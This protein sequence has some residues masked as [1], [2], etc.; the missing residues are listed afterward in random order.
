MKK[1]ILML[2]LLM[3]LPAIP[4]FSQKKTFKAACLN[5]DGL[6]P[7]VKASVTTVKLNP[8][9]PQERGTERMSELI[10]QK[11]WDFFGISEN[12]NYNDQLMSHLTGYYNTGTYRGK[13]TD[14]STGNA[15]SA[16][17]GNWSFDTDGLN[18][19]WKTQFKASNESWTLW[20]KRNGITDAGSDQLIKKGFRYYC[21]K[22]DN[23]LEIDVYIHHMDAET[24][25]ADIAARESQLN[26]LVD[27]IL[28]SDNHRPI[29]IMGDTNCRYT[30]DRLQEILF[31]RINEDLRFDI[32]DPWVDFMWDG[33]F[34]QYGTESMMVGTYGHQKGE[35]V[36]KIFYINNNDANGIVLTAN[37]YL[38]DTDFSYPDG[39]EISDH[40]PIVINF[41]IENTNTGLTGGEYYM[42]NVETGKYLCPGGWWGTHAMV[43][44]HGSHLEFVPTGE[45]QTFN[46]TTPQGK[47]G[48]N[49]YLDN[50]EYCAFKFTPTDDGYYTVTGDGKTLIVTGD[51]VVDLAEGEVVA[52]KWELISSSEMTKR[53]YQ[54]SDTN[55]MDAT[56]FIKGA[57]FDRNDADVNASWTWT[58]NSKGNQLKYNKGGINIGDITGNNYI[59][60]FKNDKFT[61]IL[62][63]KNS[64]GKLTHQSIA[65]LPN[66]KYHLSW[67]S[68]AKN[69][70]ANFKVTVNGVSTQV[71]SISDGKTEPTE[72]ESAA[73]AFNEGRYYQGIDLTITDHALN[74]V[75]EKPNT[76]S[77]TWMAFDNFELTYYG[78]T[79]ENRASYDRVLAAME[80][81]A[82]KAEAMHYYNYD[83]SVVEE[84]YENHLLSSDGSEEVHMTYIALANAAKSQNAIPADMRYVV[85][86]NSFEMG[87]FTE[88]NISGASNAQVVESDKGDGAYVA[89]AEGGR[90]SQELQV[91]MPAGLY[92]VT[93]NVSN[94]VR[95][96]AGDRKSD[97]AECE[98]GEM[99][100]ISFNFPISAGTETIGAE[101]AGAFTVDNFRIDRI[102][103]A[104]KANAIELIKSALADIPVRVATLPEPHNAPID[105]SNYQ[106]M[107]DEYAVSG[108]GMTEFIEMYGLLRERVYAQEGEIVDMTAA[109][110]NNSFEMGNMNGWDTTLS[111]DTGVKPNTDNTYHCN[112]TDGNYLFN[113]WATGHALTQV[114]Y[115]LPAGHYK[116]QALASSG[117]GSPR[118]VFLMGNEMHS[119]AI[120]IPDDKANLTEVEYEFDVADV[121][122]VAIGIIGG[123]ENGKYVAGGGNWYKADNFR[124]TRIG[125]ADMTPFYEYLQGVI[126][127]ATEKANT[128]PEAYASQWDLSDYQAIID[129]QTLEGDG[130]T[131]AAEIYAALRE[132]VYSQTEIG[133]DLT[134]NIVNNSFETGD[135]T[136]W[137]CITT[138][139]TGVRDNS[140]GTYHCDNADGKYVFNTWDSGFASA[141]TQTLTGV[142][143]GTYRLQALVAS[144]A[145]NQYFLA[146]NDNISEIITTVVKEQMEESEIIFTLEEAGDVVIGV[147]PAVNGEFVADGRGAWYKADN[148]RL[149]R[150]AAPIVEQ[151]VIWTMEGKTY[152]TLI[153]PFDVDEIPEG[154]EVYSAYECTTDTDK[155]YHVLVLD[156]VF[157]I[158]ANR[159]YVVKRPKAAAESKYRI[160]AAFEEDNSI[161]FTGEPCNEADSYTHGVLTGVLV[162]TPA[163]AG[164]YVMRHGEQIST[165]VKHAGAEEFIIPAYH[166]YI[167]ASNATNPVIFMDQDNVATAVRDLAADGDAIVDVYDMNGVV[168]ARGV[169]KA[170]ALD[171]LENGIYLFSDGTRV[172]RTK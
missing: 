105:L 153:L 131:E 121:T 75:I 32:H 155:D 112:N 15:F 36:D 43:G 168:V 26:Q 56:F 81:A 113:T 92:R 77:A 144:D 27:A 69:G 34:P 111:T 61:A 125:T 9:G 33:V 68:F 37:S 35:V 128:L 17:G 120:S 150:A 130:R 98:E 96:I 47:F 119:E 172:L 103:N 109:I 134:L 63:N 139:D 136:G 51:N 122:D 40:Y 94:G 167:D 38:H 86:N 19:L 24:G 88:W 93:A 87:N 13:I 12:F 1:V 44:A 78:E 53:L 141:V 4:A 65:G 2:C 143:A 151:N 138:N 67:Q 21:V 46:I 7:S 124:L 102:G 83:N 62:N 64:D 132:L 80:D 99:T 166:A 116:L 140:N 152:D 6:P 114:I 90:I 11:G 79:A 107:V 137:A 66:G 85:L 52:A 148:F 89:T 127:D 101:A 74:I 117:D 41:T 123:D 126:N 97:A 30:R 73:A 159:P 49:C 133:A 14:V 76:T 84:R 160:A 118:Y 169:K 18:L 164:H 25:D 60:E 8:E 108:N 147:Y 82:A 55:P 57:G 106:K 72:I 50:G 170:E 91:T 165:F 23:G 161:E 142:P 5:V 162:D 154:L 39:S 42:R 100:E 156:Q 158:R 157:D 95:L 22:I 59:G 54:A 3:A 31:G 129:N 28:A 104:E 20:N 146:A 149:S 29:L 10:A 58:Y 135:M 45:D 48:S 71:Q 115:S 163:E 110:I 70:N 145:G 16:L 171:N